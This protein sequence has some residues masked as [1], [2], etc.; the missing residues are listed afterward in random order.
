MLLQMSGFPYFSWLNDIPLLCVYHICFIH[1]SINCHLVCF[2]I[3][4]IVS[5]AAVNMGVQLS[6]QDSVFIS[7]DIYPEVGL[8]YRKVVLFLI[9]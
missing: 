1:S 2:H 3:L 8:R 6:L 5:N 7:L 4:A 9:S